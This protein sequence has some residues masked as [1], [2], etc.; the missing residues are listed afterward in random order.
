[1]KFLDA[2]THLQF[3]A[4]DADR[5]EALARAEAM[6]VRMVNIGTD[7]ETSR[8][9][10]ALAEAHPEICRATIGLHPVH[11][12]ES[13]H[14][15]EE[16]SPSTAEAFDAVAFRKLAESPYVV[17]VGECGLDYFHMHDADAKSRQAEVFAEQIDFAEEIKRPLMIHCRDAFPDLIALLKA[18]RAKLKTESAGIIH[19]FAG[20][21]D[22]ARELLDL[23]FSFTFGGALTFPEKPSRPNQYRPIVEILPLDRIISET[24]APYVAPA[25]HRG[26]RNEPAY[27]VEVV[28]K[29]A[30]VK[31]VSVV[32]MAEQILKNADLVFGKMF[33]E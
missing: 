2:H 12:S 9:A 33:T 7:L 10:V 23:G 27:V 26:E 30:E 19:F 8:A 6:G 21:Q 15:A 22:E 29:L 14:D 18:N 16:G 25:A 3:P 28:E 13:F 17:A 4:F 5:A 32:T 11:T 1:M 20:T 24:D 31:R